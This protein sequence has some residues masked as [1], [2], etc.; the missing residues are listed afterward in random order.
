M[1]AVSSRIIKVVTRAFALMGRKL[2]FFAQG[3]RKQYGLFPFA[4][5]REDQTGGK[6]DA[7][8]ENL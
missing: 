6:K 3:K 4:A 5:A 8:G 2:I 1:G 7:V